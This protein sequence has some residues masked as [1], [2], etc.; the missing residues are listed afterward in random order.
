MSTPGKSLYDAGFVEWTARTT[1]LLRL[2]RLTGLDLENVA[3]EIEDLG[4]SERSAVRSQLRRM[5]VHLMKAR[6]QPERAG[7]VG[8]LRQAE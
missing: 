6:I 1:D 4:K 8:G 7:P 2:G 3:E 5:V